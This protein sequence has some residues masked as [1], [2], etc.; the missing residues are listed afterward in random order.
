MPAEAIRTEFSGKNLSGI[1]PTGRPWS[2]DIFAD[3]TTDYRE[4]EVRRP[5]KWWL[6][7]LEFCFS[8]PQ[9]GEGGCFRVVKISSNCYE[10]YDFS[11]HFGR[12]DAP[13]RLKGAWNGRMWRLEAPSTCQDQPTA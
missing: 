11:S 4:P 7:S 9:P 13:P 1:Y 3:G 5:G 6:T 2:E 12:L 10:L 8:Y